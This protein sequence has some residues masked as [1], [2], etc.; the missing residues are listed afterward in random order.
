MLHYRTRVTLDS[1]KDEIDLSR[2]LIEPMLQLVANYVPYIE[3]FL[4]VTVRQEP[5]LKDSIDYCVQ[6]QKLSNI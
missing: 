5:T 1:I 3:F 4:D 6:V 2:A